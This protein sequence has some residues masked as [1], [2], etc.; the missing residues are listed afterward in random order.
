MHCKL[1]CYIWLGNYISLFVNNQKTKKKHDVYN[2]TDNNIIMI[3]YMYVCLYVFLCNNSVLKTSLL[4]T[5]DDC[6]SV[7]CLNSFNFPDF[8]VT[9]LSG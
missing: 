3:K 4:Q 6:P 5:K 9:I 1:C 8:C 7:F 2:F